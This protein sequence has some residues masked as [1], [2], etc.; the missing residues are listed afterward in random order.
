MQDNFRHDVNFPLLLN[1]LDYILSALESLQGDPGPREIKY[2]ILHLAN[3]IE[4]VFKERLKREHWALLFERIDNASI[5]EYEKGVFKSVSFEKCIDRLINIC[6]V[7]ITKD[8]ETKLKKFL[9]DKRNQLSHFGI[10]DSS[11]AL[12]ANT[13]KTLVFLIDFINQELKP[14]EFDD[15]YIELYNEIKS[16]M[17]ELDKFVEER[18]KAIKNRLNGKDPITCPNCFQDA[19]LIEDGLNCAF[20]G[21]T[22]DPVEAAKRYVE[23]VLNIYHEDYLIED[24]IRSCPNCYFET[25]VIRDGFYRCFSCGAKWDWMDNCNLC[26][27]PIDRDPNDVDGL[28]YCEHCIELIWNKN[29]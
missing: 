29:D 26:G 20:C 14:N 24:P 19:A 5:S 23:D 12:K 7:N 16:R 18:W 11:E 9:R 25:L 15:E 2:A 8:Q 22:A 10:S 1:G 21:Y 3:G 28:S 4:L 27:Q 6:Q 13:Y 17:F